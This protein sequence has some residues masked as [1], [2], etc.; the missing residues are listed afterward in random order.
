[1]SRIAAWADRCTCGSR[2]ICARSAPLVP[3]TAQ[4]AQTAHGIETPGKFAAPAGQKTP[5]GSTE[6]TTGTDQARTRHATGGDISDLVSAE[7]ARSESLG[8]VP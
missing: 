2:I 3:E 5:D 1:M 4:T 6:L 8:A 7:S